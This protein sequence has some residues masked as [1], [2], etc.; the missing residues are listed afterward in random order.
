MKIQIESYNPEWAISFEQIK[1]DLQAILKEFN[2]RI[3]HIGSTSIPNLAAKPIID[4]AVGIDSAKDL[5]RT[6]EPM[7]GSHYIYYEVYNSSM[8]LRRFFVGLKNKK[9]HSKF[10]N[11]YRE[12]D[13]IPHEEIHAHKLC[14]VHI[15]EYGTPEWFRHIA[16]R[17]YLIENP[18]IRDRYETLKKN[19]SEQDWCDGNEY[20]SAKN[21]FIKAEEANAL[22][23]YRRKQEQL[24]KNKRH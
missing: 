8:P 14:H 18:E 13:S 3:E 4:I 12:G 2:P 15:W 11:I 21:N 10:K 23:W 24:T 16:F 19:L 9:D 1:K 20:S 22:L 5:D 17:D 7:L 6:I